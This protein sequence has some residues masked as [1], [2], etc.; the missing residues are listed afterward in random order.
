M[1][2]KPKPLKNIQ[3]YKAIMQKKCSKKYLLIL[4]DSNRR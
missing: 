1:E 4:L 3:T 2:I